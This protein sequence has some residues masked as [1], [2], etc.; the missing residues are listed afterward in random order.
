LSCAKTFTDSSAVVEGKTFAILPFQVTIIKDIN[1]KKTTKAQL[2]EIAKQEAYRYQTVSFNYIMNKQ[3]DYYVSFQPIEETNALLKK[4]K[5]SY[6]KLSE[7]SSE[8]LSKILKVDGILI[9][10]MHRREVMPQL[11]A[12]GLDILQGS[13]SLRQRATTVSVG[14]NTTANTVNMG[15]TLYSKIN[16]RIIWTYQYDV[17]GDAYN[18]PENMANQLM[19]NAAKKFPFKKKKQ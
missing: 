11:M 4:N 6:E 8:Y 14:D 13:G 15:L 12:K 10:K 16:T 18:T 19:L 1:F 7:M 5:I 3:K 9:G 2:D 17:N